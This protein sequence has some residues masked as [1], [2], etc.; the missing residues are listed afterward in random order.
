[1]LLSVACAALRYHTAD[2][3]SH[4]LAALG[5]AAALALALRARREKS[6]NV[7]L[8]AGIALSVVLAT[9]PVSALPIGIVV[10][11]LTRSRKTALGIVRGA[12]VVLRDERRSAGM[13][14]LGLRPGRRLPLR[15]RGVRARAL[16]PRLRDRGGRG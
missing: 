8:A 7:A 6:A 9:R 16:A 15:A 14:P 5:V 2:T 13:F 3:M 4:G 11:W 1:A 10:L 12:V